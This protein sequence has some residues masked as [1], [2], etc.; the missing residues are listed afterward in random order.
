MAVRIFRTA[1]LVAIAALCAFG[2]KLPDWYT[3]SLPDAVFE[4]RLIQSI[5]EIQGVAGDRLDGEVTLVEVRV[6]PL[7]GA[8]LSLSRDDFLLRA[9]NTN[10]TSPARTPD[11]VAGGGVLDLA[12]KTTNSSPGLF[13]DESAGPVW[14]GLPGTGTRPRRLGGPPAGVGGG[15]TREE[16][17]TVEGRH[18]GSGTAAERLQAAELPLEMSD[19]P[20]GGYLY[21]EIPTKVK[22]KH[23]ELSYDGGLGE[24]RVEFKRPE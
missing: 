20:A 1:C 4:V 8:S 14:G 9:R 5:E 16:V 24:F 3:R 13:A 15:A 18:Q 6:R 17:R 11:R 21:F 12:A 23:L 10:D 7:Y 22:R 19:D 2:A